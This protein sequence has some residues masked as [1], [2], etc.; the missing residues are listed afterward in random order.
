MGKHVIYRSPAK[1]FAGHL[2]RGKCPET[3]CLYTFSSWY[4][5]IRSKGCCEHNPQTRKAI[6]LGEVWD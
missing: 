1:A 4:A 3:N 6:R 5:A 2:W